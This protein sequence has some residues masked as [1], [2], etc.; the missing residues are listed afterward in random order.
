MNVLGKEKVPKRVSLKKRKDSM[1]M[2]LV[3]KS[4]NKHIHTENKTKL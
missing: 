2:R 3:Q 4:L 1:R